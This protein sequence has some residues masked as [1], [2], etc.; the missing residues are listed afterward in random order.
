MNRWLGFVVSGMREY[1]AGVS[2]LSEAIQLRKPKLTNNRFGSGF[3]QTTLVFFHQIC[4]E[5]RTVGA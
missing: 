5:A 4:D 1:P 3:A 2:A